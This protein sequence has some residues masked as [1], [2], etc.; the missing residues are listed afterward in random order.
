[1]SGLLIFYLPQEIASP[2]LCTRPCGARNDGIEDQ[3]LLSTIYCL[4]QEIASPRL[5]TGPWGARNDGIED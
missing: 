1:M 5:C 4:L 3:G 2:R